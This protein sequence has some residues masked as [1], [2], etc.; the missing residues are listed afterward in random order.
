MSVVRSFPFPRCDESM[1][2]EGEM[3]RKDM[4][5]SCVPAAS[6]TSCSHATSC[7]VRMASLGQLVFESAGRVMSISSPM[8]GVVAKT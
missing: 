6:S 4:V 1:S 3:G 8:D 5:N 7:F 2:R